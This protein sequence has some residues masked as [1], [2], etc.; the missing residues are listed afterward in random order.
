MLELFVSSFFFF[1]A[2]DGIR[3]LTVTGVQTC[4]LPISPPGRSRQRAQRSCHEDEWTGYADRC[5]GSC[6]RRKPARD[7]DFARGAKGCRDIAR[8]LA[9]GLWPRPSA[10]PF[11]YFP[12][13]PG[14]TR[15]RRGEE[16]HPR[17]AIRRLPIRL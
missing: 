4:A 11:R 9:G 8:R 17:A 5:G 14:G 3:Y 7:T 6:S 15:L 13:S 2:E 10:P 16:P 12:G 1:Q